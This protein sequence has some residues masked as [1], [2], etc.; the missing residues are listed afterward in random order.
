MINTTQFK[1]YYPNL[2]LFANPNLYQK[3]L[4][5]AEKFQKKSREKDYQKAQ[6]RWDK[7]ASKIK[8]SDLKK[9]DFYYQIRNGKKVR[10]RINKNNLK[11]LGRKIGDQKVGSYDALS[12]NVTAG[13]PTVRNYKTNKT[14][15]FKTLPKATR[16][17]ILK[18]QQ[19]HVYNE[20]EKGLVTGRIKKKDLD[21]LSDQEKRKYS[22]FKSKK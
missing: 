7:E 9:K 2:V 21:Y 20:M 3:T 17:K 22:V 6:K 8:Y 13:L 15:P 18:A 4:L 16:K 14:V 11:S 12:V 10:V 1:A 19:E 5:W